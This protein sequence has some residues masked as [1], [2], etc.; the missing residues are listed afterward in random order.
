MEMPSYPRVT[1]SK[2]SQANP[3]TATGMHFD[4]GRGVGTY[5]MGASK[6]GPDVAH[7]L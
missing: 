4:A 3:S 1:I 5:H 7:F 2:V 6:F